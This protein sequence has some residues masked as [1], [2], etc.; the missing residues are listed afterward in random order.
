MTVLLFIAA[1]AWPLDLIAYLSAEQS[2]YAGSAGAIFAGT[3]QVDT[4][5]VRCLAQGQHTRSA[6]G[7][8]FGLNPDTEFRNCSWHY[9]FPPHFPLE[10]RRVMVTIL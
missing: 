4:G 5:L 10:R 6:K 8:P 1:Q 9:F 7:Q 2:A 3:R